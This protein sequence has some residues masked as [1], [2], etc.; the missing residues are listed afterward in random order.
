[1]SR[2]TERSTITALLKRIDLKVRFNQTL[3]HLSVASCL[4]L[5]ALVLIELLPRLVPVTMPP[6][7]LI[8][9]AGSAAFL[10]FL[11]RS[12]LGGRQL[13]RAAGVAARRR[14]LG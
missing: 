2:A 6:E 8:V 11:L 13:E 10:A 3:L 12:Q 14:G 5:G 7:G 1:M 4:V 9:G